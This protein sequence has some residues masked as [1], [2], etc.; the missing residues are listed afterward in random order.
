[1]SNEYFANLSTWFWLAVAN[2]LWQSTLFLLLV[3]ISI[4]AL[5]KS[6]ARARYTVWLV[7]SLKFALPL[8][9]F[10]AFGQWLD[11]GSFLPRAVAVEPHF[12]K[13]T[14]LVEI[15]STYTT[16]AMV[17]LLRPRRLTTKYIIC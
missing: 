16:G 12:Y 1:M 5:K 17:P 15:V 2:H 9:V 8:S 10:V 6:P 11:I 7:A 3:M 14:G 13:S 4:A